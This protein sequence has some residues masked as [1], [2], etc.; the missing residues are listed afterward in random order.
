[1]ISQEIARILLDTKSVKLSTNPPF[2]YTSGIKSPIYCDNRKLISFVVERERI[3][4]GFISIIK[5]MPVQ[6][7]VLGG[8]AT[9]AIPWAAF[10]AEKLKLAMVY[11]RP[12]P[13]GHGAGKQ[14]EGVLTEGSK[15]LII[16][17]LISTGGSSINSANAIRNEGKSSVLGV[18]AIMTYN[19]P[20][21]I[22][23]FQDAVVNVQVLTDFET[24]MSVAK[25][26][27]ALNEQDYQLACE[28]NKNPENWTV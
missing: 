24:L 18:L 7:D 1:M 19:M 5:N 23:N 16:E 8:T 14:I 10:L 6:P 13:K 17:D 11:I 22:A 9:A 15:V 12:E 27:G 20:K 3:L 26:S 4:E 21:A 25:D 28:W 2:T